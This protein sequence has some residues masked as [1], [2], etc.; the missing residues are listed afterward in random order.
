M[1]HDPSE[2]MLICRFGSQTFIIIINFEQLCCLILL[3]CKWFG[4]PN[5]TFYV[6]KCQF[7]QS[8]DV[9][10]KPFNTATWT[11]EHFQSNFFTVNGTLCLINDPWFYNA[12]LFWNIKGICWWML[13]SFFCGFSHFS[14]SL[15][16]TQ[17][18]GE[19][20]S[21]AYFVLIYVSNACSRRGRV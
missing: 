19:F 14:I 13:F 8:N 21:F 15:R 3:Y 2:I 1:S 16:R 18:R 10:W 17:R 5:S 20:L 11:T 6:E 12:S 9:N 7:A 4:R